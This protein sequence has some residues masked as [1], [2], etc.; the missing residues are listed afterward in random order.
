MVS[1][2]KKSVFALL[3]CFGAV[4]YE[5]LIAGLMNQVYQSDAYEAFA[6]VLVNRGK[7]ALISGEQ[8]KK[9]QILRETT[10][11]IGIREHKNTKF[12]GTEEQANLFQENNGT[13]TQPER[14]LHITEATYYSIFPIVMQANKC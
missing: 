6:G 5:L 8:R 2:S 7:R 11:I 12:E 10:T 1:E 13:G 3:D 9:C 4:L 14:A